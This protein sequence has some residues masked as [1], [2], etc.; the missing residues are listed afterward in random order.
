M[1]SRALV[2]FF[3]LLST[4]TWGQAAKKAVVPISGPEERTAQYLE[5]IRH[6]PSLLLHFL[7]ALPKGGDLHLHLSGSIYAESYVQW[8]AQDGLCVSRQTFA[9]VAPPCD[10]DK[11]VVPATQVLTE[12]VLYQQ[13][14]NAQSMRF[15]D[16]PESGHDHFFNAFGKF[17]AVSRTRQGDMLAEVASRAASEKLTYLEVLLSPDKGEAGRLATENHLQ[18]KDDFAAA[19]ETLMKDG[20]ARAVEIGRKNLDAFEARMKEV[21]KCGTAHADPGCAV[22]VRY[23]YEIHRGLAPEVVF[24]EM[25]VGFEMAKADPRV[26]DVNPVMPEDAYV[27]MRDFELHM[28]MLE[29]LH[30]VYPGVLLSLHAGELWKGVVPPEGLRYHIRDSVERGHAKRIGHGVDVMFENDAVGLLKELAAKKIAVEVN[31]SSNDLILGVRGD[32]HPLPMYLKFGVPVAISTDDL[33]VSRSDMTQEYFRA[34]SSYPIGYRELKNMVRNSLEY[35]FL[36][37]GSLWS[38]VTKGK[39]IAA[40][41]NAGPKCDQFLESSEKAR[42]QWKLEQDIA[43]FEAGECC[44]ISVRG[45]SSVK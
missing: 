24:A 30:R 26:V 21:L 27:P 12:A 39:R 40:C 35:S 17:G 1:R 8:A 36:G 45:G 10:A 32:E 16:G 22:T 34:V 6:Q 15:F 42:L 3:A 29:Y 11:N 20:L 44:T 41:T 33:G 18:L 43:R 13:I 4:Y 9:F 28:R 25:V 23:Q 19:R 7:R 31:L 38:D 5:E 2:F 37:G 14:I